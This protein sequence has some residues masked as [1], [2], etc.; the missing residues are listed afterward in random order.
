M[1]PSCLAGAA[2]PPTRR[3]TPGGPRT[4]AA[5]AVSAPP[6]AAATR[7]CSCA[8]Q[9]CAS[10]GGL[11]AGVP[12]AC[13]LQLA[14]CCRPLLPTRSCLRRPLPALPPRRVGVLL[15]RRPGHRQALRPARV[16]LRRRVVRARCWVLPGCSA[17]LLL[18]ASLLLLA[19]LLPPAALNH[20]PCLPSSPSGAELPCGHTCPAACHDGDCPPCGL[21]STVRCRCGAEAA[22]L[23]CSEQGLFQASVAGLGCC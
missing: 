23:P 22:E 21:V 16:Q 2:R 19:T 8:T 15:L 14:G 13:R 3:G 5:S 12:L 7:A 18:L 17:C 11:A 4:R 6:P 9:V 1:R 20:L 10:G